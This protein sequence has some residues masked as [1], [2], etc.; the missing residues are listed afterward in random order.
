[1]NELY[2]EI[3]DGVGIFHKE[4]SLHFRSFK[5]T[6]GCILIQGKMAKCTQK[7]KVC[8]D[9][10]EIIVLAKIHKVPVRIC[11]VFEGQITPPPDVTLSQVVTERNVYLF[12]MLNYIMVVMVLSRKLKKRRGSVFHK[13]FVFIGNLCRKH[14]FR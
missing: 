9:N 11:L 1:M 4:N 2:V 14:F 13:N 10:V 12:L 3:V 7:D 8:S 5:I 6:C